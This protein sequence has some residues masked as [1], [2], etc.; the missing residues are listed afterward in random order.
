[1]VHKWKGAAGTAMPLHAGHP[2]QY[3]SWHLVVF[4]PNRRMGPPNWRGRDD[5]VYSYAMLPTYVV[6]MLVD[7]HKPEATRSR[8]SITFVWTVGSIDGD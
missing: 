5:E 7:H 4:P 1:M 6:L 3:I 2:E 8:T